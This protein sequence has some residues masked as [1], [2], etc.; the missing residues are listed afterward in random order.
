MDSDGPDRPG[1]VPRRRVARLGRATV[2]LVAIAVGLLVLA[3]VLLLAADPKSRAESDALLPL[4][5]TL[6]GSTVVV[7][8]AAGA[9][10]AATFVALS[11]LVT[12][13]AMRVL[14]PDRT[15]PDPLPE[16][17][18]RFRRVVLAPAALRRLEVD[19]P[20]EWPVTAIPQVG[21]LPPPGAAC[22]A[23]C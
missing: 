11:G 15:E 18:Q 2:I 10:T 7:F 1:S 6:T 21:E 13:A 20:P 22:S 3:V 16:G 9:L 12:A 8:L 17:V 23:T 4:N 5:A 19:H 14:S